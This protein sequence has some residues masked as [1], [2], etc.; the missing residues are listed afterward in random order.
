[1][2]L[3]AQVLGHSSAETT[4]KFYADPD[5]ACV[6]RSMQKFDYAIKDIHSDSKF[7]KLAGG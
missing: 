1:M 7:R 3:T 4:R 6:D 5:Q 2:Y